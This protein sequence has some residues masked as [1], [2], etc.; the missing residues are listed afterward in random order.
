M[1]DIF[2]NPFSNSNFQ[3]A[4][5]TVDVSSSSKVTFSIQSSPSAWNIKDEY[6]SSVLS[7]SG[8]GSYKHSSIS[9]VPSKMSEGSNTRKVEITN[10]MRE[11]MKI[12][13]SA[14]SLTLVGCITSHEIFSQ[15]L[16]EKGVV[17]L[18]GTVYTKHSISSS[19][20]PDGIFIFD[21]DE[22]FIE[23]F[24]EEAVKDV[25]LALEA[26]YNSSSFN[27]EEN[28]YL[29]R[30]DRLPAEYDPSEWGRTIDKEEWNLNLKPDFSGFMKELRSDISNLFGDL[31]IADFSIKINDQGEMTVFDVKTVG[32][33][34]KTNAQITEQIN[35]RLTYEIKKEAEYLGLLMFSEHCYE[36]GD[37]LMEGILEPFDDGSRGNIQ[38]VKHEVI[39]TSDSDY[40]VI[41][42][43][44]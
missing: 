39:I 16:D 10:A 3:S 29:F 27:L 31:Q 41:S 13:G 30:K 32:N 2:Q 14:M 26:A 23:G 19:I 38:L 9:T 40:K 15:V 34:S 17:S 5:Q 18:D 6:I 44:G 25:C 11:E 35:S 28:P 20:N 8:S 36:E 7:S 42:L 33:N 21:P 12:L 22:S 37:V 4:Q 1:I 43:G 24:D